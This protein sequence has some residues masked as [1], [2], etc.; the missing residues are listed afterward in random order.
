[1]SPSR[2]CHH[3]GGPGRSKDSVESSTQRGPPT[4]GPNSRSSTRSK[5]SAGPSAMI[6]QCKE[7]WN[8]IVVGRY[9]GATGVGYVALASRLVD[10]IGFA[11]RATW[12][13]GLVVLAKVQSD[14]AR[15]RRGIE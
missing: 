14:A 11:Q 10:T 15:V 13:L 2:R 7:S 8:P 6:T 12:R 1:M 5:A 9:F 4:Q 3:L